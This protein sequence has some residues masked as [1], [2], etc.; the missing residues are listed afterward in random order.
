VH[1][2]AGYFELAQGK[3]IYLFTASGLQEA[4]GNFTINRTIEAIQ[5]VDGFAEVG[6]GR[7]AKTRRVPEGGTKRLYHID[8]ETLLQK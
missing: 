8:P 4:V 3:K 1:N 7:I 6:S 5:A 2:Q